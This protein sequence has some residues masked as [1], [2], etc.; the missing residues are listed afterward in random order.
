MPN[1]CHEEL[2]ES[3]PEVCRLIVAKI[4]RHP[5][6]SPRKTID[7]YG[8]LGAGAGFEPAAFRFCA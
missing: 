6:I 5:E 8:V 1:S 2:L 4:W 3:A 7:L